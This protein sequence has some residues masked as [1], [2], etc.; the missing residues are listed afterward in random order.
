[1][2]QSRSPSQTAFLCVVG[3]DLDFH[4]ARIF[5]ELLHVDF[6]IAEGSTGFRLV[7]APR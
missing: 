3:Q 7:M 1:M 4:V 6:R 5:Q 2:E